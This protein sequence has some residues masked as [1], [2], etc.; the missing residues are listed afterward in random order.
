MSAVVIS[1]LQLDFPIREI[2][3]SLFPIRSAKILQKVTLITAISHQLAES[4][5]V[6]CYFFAPQIRTCLKWGWFGEAIRFFFRFLET[7]LVPGGIAWQSFRQPDSFMGRGKTRMDADFPQ[8]MVKSS[9]RVFRVD[10][11]PISVNCQVIRNA[12]Q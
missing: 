4:N 5:F 2:E 7:K 11:R 10:P 9:F 8:K 6:H 12:S 1:S 3:H